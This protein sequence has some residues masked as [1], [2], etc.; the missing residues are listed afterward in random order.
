MTIRFPS[1][2][3]TEFCSTLRLLLKLQ[4]WFGSMYHQRFYGQNM[5]FQS[6]WDNQMD[7]NRRYLE[8]VRN[9]IGGPNCSIL[10]GRQK[11]EWNARFFLALMVMYNA[12][13]PRKTF[14]AFPV[15]DIIDLEKEAQLTHNFVHAEFLDLCKSFSDYLSEDG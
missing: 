8:A 5:T 15:Q 13:L 14:R 9:I 4:S 6:D 3:D 2:R 12:N 1:L 10:D 7:K 11:P